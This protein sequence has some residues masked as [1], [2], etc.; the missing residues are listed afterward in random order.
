M[1]EK[2]KDQQPPLYT[3][4]RQHQKDSLPYNTTNSNDQI[5]N[6]FNIIPQWQAQA[7][8]HDKRIKGRKT[9]LSTKKSFI[10]MSTSS[11]TLHNC[12]ACVDALASHRC[13]PGSIPGVVMWDGQVRRVGFLQVLRFP[14]TQRPSKSKHRCRRAWFI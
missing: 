6:N 8:N 12:I 11:Y 3:W 4:N 7:K 9:W 2:R 13:D 5:Y 14:P 10:Y 1:W